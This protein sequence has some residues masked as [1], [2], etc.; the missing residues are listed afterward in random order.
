MTG[1]WSMASGLA[2][3]LGIA[4]IILAVI[5][6][7]GCKTVFCCIKPHPIKPKDIPPEQWP[8]LKPVIK[9]L[10]QFGF[11]PVGCR[12]AEAILGTPFY[13]VILRHKTSHTYAT[14]IVGLSSQS[15]S[16]VNIHLSTH[17][18]N[19]HLL[20]TVNDA[21]YDIYS[22][23]PRH[24]VQWVGYVSIKEQIEAHRQGFM[25][26]KKDSSP[27]RLSLKDFLAAQHHHDHLHYARLA[28]RREIF[29]V[30]PEHTYRMAPWTAVRSIMRVALGMKRP[31]NSSPGV[32]APN[33]PGLNQ[34]GEPATTAH[35]VD[36]EVAAFMRSR[37][38]SK[39]SSSRRNRT[40]ILLASLAL[41]LVASSSMFD[42]RL[43]WQG[44]LAFAG[45]IAIHEAGHALAMKAFG[46]RDTTVLFVPFF[47]ALATAKKEDA[48]L[49]EKVWISLAGPLPGIGLGIGLA[50]AR[51]QGWVPAWDWID[52]TIGFFLFLNLFNLIPFYPLDG[53]QVANHLLF[54][55]NPYLGV[56]FQ[57][58]GIAA[59]ALLGL[60]T[61]SFLLLGFA[62]LVAFSIPQ[63]FRTAK[64]NAQLRQEILSSYPVRPAS[65]DQASTGVP[66]VPELGMDT[67]VR[68]IF[69]ILQSPSYG[70]LTF[71]QKSTLAKSLL[72][73]RTEHMAPFMTRIGLSGI[74]I[75]SLI[76]G[77]IG[78]VYA[79]SL[80]STDSEIASRSI[81]YSHSKTGFLPEA[82]EDDFERFYDQEFAEY[83][84]NEYFTDYE[85]EV[86]NIY[87]CPNLDAAPLPL[88]AENS[89]VMR[90]RQ[91]TLMA[92]FETEAIA[93]SVLATLQPSLIPSDRALVF[94]QSVLVST[95]SQTTQSQF[96]SV[97]SDQEGQLLPIDDLEFGVSIYI[98]AEAPD[99][100]T[101]KQVAQTF[102]FFET[103]GLYDASYVPPMPW[104][105]PTLTP[106]QQALSQRAKYTYRR[107]KRIEED[108]W[109]NAPIKGY[110][111]KSILA[112]VTRN[113]Q[114]ITGEQKK[115][116]EK[117]IK[118]VRNGVKALLESDDPHLD[119][120]TLNLYLQHANLQHELSQLQMD[121]L[122]QQPSDVGAQEGEFSAPTQANLQEQEQLYTTVYQVQQRLGQRMWQTSSRYAPD[123]APIDPTALEFDPNRPW[124]NGYVQYEGTQMQFHELNFSS[125]SEMLPEMTQY[126]CD[127]QF[128]NI[129]YTFVNGAEVWNY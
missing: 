76:L 1:L 67:W 85:A 55:R 98:D 95:V 118:A 39:S 71:A 74:Y 24:H 90:D 31:K 102:W 69:T 123:E 23:E 3:P 77:G 64:L 108:A 72:D 28:K 14:L 53:G 61:G 35:Q 88:G 54:S 16:L 104:E 46:Y 82:A 51:S 70:R 62:A 45:V 22:I 114:W 9:E 127:R 73:S 79:L 12:Q 60:G 83:S 112:A 32:N 84:E 94:G 111:W 4:L 99:E 50:I 96:E 75:A 27:Q 17:W 29:W 42:G 8:L 110:L 125:V 63:N 101:A 47:G 2:I 78:S 120:E 129:R 15:A 48:T 97:T 66:S 10:Q 40:F 21:T 65:S 7:A 117:Q 86:S 115:M 119:P 128:T 80:D 49:T 59:L 26:I 25:A 124:F 41:F 109:G 68:R 34:S 5:V 81:E 126:L 36:A 38:P 52:Q 33:A 92:T 116:M 89:D 13:M 107:L 30:E 91:V 121:E 19:G 43:N 113:P 122:W 37:Q 93:Q 11:K 20:E 100:Q 106:D 57:S 87:S 56:A 105:S 44:L 6:W 58:I 18:T 103:L